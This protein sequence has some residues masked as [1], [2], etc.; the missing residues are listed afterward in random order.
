MSKNI[1]GEK[2][3]KFMGRKV[4]PFIFRIGA[5]T[6]W[7][8]RWFNRKQ[9]RKLLE[10]DVKLRD[11]VMKK[12]SRAGINSVEIERSANLVNIIIETARPGLVI[13]RGGGGIEELKQELKKLIQ[14]RDHEAVNTEVRLE[15]KEVRQPN[16]HAAIVAADMASQIERRMPYRRVMKQTLDKIM[17]NK[18]VQGAKVMAK[19]RLN[20]AEIARKEW[21]SK[22]KIS[23]QT[24]R[25]NIDYAQETAYTAYGTIGIKVWIYK[26]EVFE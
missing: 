25:A 1:L 23:L 17:Q 15:I 18:E 13:G 24:L 3:Y 16:S 4:H 12:L 20:G 11:F 14:K 21:L 2:V 10:Q 6:N 7:K 9:Y 5:V 8:S 22:G 26:G 19:G